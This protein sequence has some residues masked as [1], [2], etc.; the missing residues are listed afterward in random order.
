MTDSLETVQKERDLLKKEVDILSEQLKHLVKAEHALT[1]ARRRSERQFSRIRRLADLALTIVGVDGANRV[2]DDAERALFDCYEFDSVVTFQLDSRQSQVCFQSKQFEVDDK[3]WRVMAQ[4]AEPKVLDPQNPMVELILPVLSATG[5]ATSSSP[6]IMV[7]V[8]LG[9][10]TGQQVIMMGWATHSSINH[11]EL[12]HVENLA[13]LQLFANHV[14]RALDTAVEKARTVSVTCELRRQGEALALANQQLQN[15]LSDL[16]RTQGQLVQAQKLEALGRLSGGIAHDFNNLLTVIITHAHLAKD[17]MEKFPEAKED[18]AAI[19]DAA[20]RA[21]QITKRLLAFGRK[22]EHHNQKVDVNVLVTDLSRMLRRLIGDDIVLNLDLDPCLGHVRADAVQ[23][24]QVLLNLIV[25]ARDAMPRGGKLTIETRRARHT[26]QLHD[27]RMAGSN[28][29]ALSVSDT[30]IGMDETTR[31]QLFEPFFTTKP[32]GNGTGLG[33]ATVYGLVKQNQG[34]ILVT[35]T[36]G[37]GSCF[38]VLLPNA[39]TP[40]DSAVIV[41]SL[42]KT[43]GTVMV[44]EDEDVIRRMVSRVLRKAGFDVTEARDGEEALAVAKRLPRLDLLVTDV[45][46]PNLNGPQLVKGLRVAIPDLKVVFMSGHTYDRLQVHTLDP[47]TE[48][49]LPKPFN[50]DQLKEIVDKALELGS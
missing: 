49:F 10:R 32:V 34:E 43:R 7:L 27:G 44:V 42:T 24:E 6:K 31:R 14:T 2:L 46:M 5:A 29:I 12:I 41:S 26:D 13:F 1:S 35:S 4:L 3:A 20:T 9:L 19:V 17:A 8:P 50:P 37:T 22:Q 18:L 47:Q 33:L 39:E 25:N 11:R 36:L 30:G 15:S 40:A 23:M 16:E 21:T 38:T 45:V 28:F 48:G